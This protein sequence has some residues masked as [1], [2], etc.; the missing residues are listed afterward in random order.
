MKKDLQYLLNDLEEVI[1]GLPPREERTGEEKDLA[2]ALGYAAHVL[3]EQ[4]V[5]PERR[6]ELVSPVSGGASLVVYDKHD[7]FYPGVGVMYRNPSGLEI[8]L[9][10]VETD[11]PVSDNPDDSS[12]MGGYGPDHVRIY[13]YGDP[14]RDDFT[15]KFV[16][17]RPE[18]DC[19]G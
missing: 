11:G 5:K 3:K 14:E 13:V 6:E 7:V 10:L 9:V 1:S 19:Q 18:M 12:Q 4:G 2:L 15:E 16:L 8:E 17:S